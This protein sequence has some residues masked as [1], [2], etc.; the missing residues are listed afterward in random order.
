MTEVLI[1]I[2]SAPIN[3]PRF[4]LLM[5]FVMGTISGKAAA[6]WHKNLFATKKV[7]VY[8]TY[9]LKAYYFLLKIN[10]N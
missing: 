9:M 6:L 3:I 8:L 4:Q 1:R 7:H 2:I 10:K 5:Y